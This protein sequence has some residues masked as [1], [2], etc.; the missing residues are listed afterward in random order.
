ML[1]HRDVKV[2]TDCFM[3]NS[4]QVTVPFKPPLTESNKWIVSSSEALWAPSPAR[5]LTLGQLGSLYNAAAHV[6]FSKH[7]EETVAYTCILTL[8]MQLLAL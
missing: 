5:T 6:F 1:G 2:Q 3:G 8:I 4:D 7:F